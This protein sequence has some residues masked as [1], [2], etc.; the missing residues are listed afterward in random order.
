[1]D[2]NSKSP[3]FPGQ[4]IIISSIFS[5]IFIAGLPFLG[6]FI[7]KTEAELAPGDLVN[8]FS[9]EGLVLL[10]KNTLIPIANPASPEPKVVRKLS[11]IITAYSS[12]PWETD[13]TPFLTAAG[14]WVKDGIIANNL[15]P[16]GTKVKIPE[17]YG[18]KI[19]IVEDRMNWEKGDFHVDIWFPSYW[20]ALNFGAKTTYIEILES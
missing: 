11:V 2:Y 4:R 17:I 7:P 5:A 12:T 10:G 15:L 9:Q 20:Q 18:D 19:F 3:G 16:F 6:V 13:D 8:P 1:M 14:T